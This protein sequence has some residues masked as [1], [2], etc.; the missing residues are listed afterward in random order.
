MCKHPAGHIVPSGL[1]VLVT[2]AAEE[3]ELERSLWEADD[4]SWVAIFVKI[5]PSKG[6]PKAGE[7]WVQVL[8]TK[9]E[10]Y[11]SA[12]QLLTDIDPELTGKHDLVMVLHVDELPK[13]LLSNP[14][15]YFKAPP[16]GDVAVPQAADGG[17][18]GDVSMEV[19]GEGRTH[20]EEQQD[21]GEVLEGVRLSSET[22]LKGTPRVV[23][24]A[25]SCTIRREA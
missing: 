7:V 25:R 10:D 15:D 18:V 21:E 23:Q 8:A 1:P 13:D 6:L 4:W 17:G 16:S 19:I 9:T 14:R 12:P 5:D 24:Q 11:E 3:L 22:P 20:E 2:H